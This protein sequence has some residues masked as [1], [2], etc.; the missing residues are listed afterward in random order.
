MK[1]NKIIYWVATGLF[2]LIT[3]LGATNF[4]FN[5]AEVAT[6]IFEPL[7]Y[8]AVMVIPLGIAKVLGIAAILLKPLSSLKKLAYFAL[9]A[10]LLVALG[11]HL[12]VGVGEWFPPLVPFVLGLLSFVYWGKIK[13]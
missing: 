5:S 10:E 8:P 13:E 12:V 3:L 11:S 4:I 9:L 7:G 2:S 1:T 6:T